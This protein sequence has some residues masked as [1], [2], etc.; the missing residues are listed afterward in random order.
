MMWSIWNPC[1]EALGGCPRNS[2]IS[3]RLF[4]VVQIFNQLLM[5]RGWHPA[6]SP[7]LVTERTDS[8]HHRHDRAKQKPDRDGHM[9]RRLPVLRAVTERTGA[10]LLRGEHGDQ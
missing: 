1:S 9:L 3:A 4:I 8:S 10:R 7:D 2:L 5:R 6:V